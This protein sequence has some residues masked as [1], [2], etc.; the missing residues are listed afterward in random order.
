MP[1]EELLAAVRNDRIQFATRRPEGSP[2]STLERRVVVTGPPELV[3]LSGVGD[4]RVLDALVRLLEDRERGWAAEV[5]LAAMT[6]REDQIV[7]S[8]ATTPDQWW[9]T[10]GK[11][12]KDR[13]ADWLAQTRHR[14]TWDPDDKVFIAI[15]T[16]E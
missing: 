15:D 7:D 12:A 3:T 5:L 8:F 1:W 14:L 4:I 9:E 16:E 6:H 11:T 2:F 10:V 13:W